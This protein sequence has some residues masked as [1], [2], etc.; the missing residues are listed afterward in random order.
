MLHLSIDEVEQ[1]GST[2]ITGDEEMFKTMSDD[3]ILF[4]HIANDDHELYRL[5]CCLSELF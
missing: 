3:D 4:Y 5:D 1:E 2:A